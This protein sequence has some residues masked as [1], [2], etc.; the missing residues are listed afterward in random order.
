MKEIVL[1]FLRRGVVACGLGPVVLAVV[2]FILHWVTGLEIL[3]VHEVCV[4]ILSLTGLAFLAGGMN[5]VYRI[6]Q[7]P[8]M[9]AIL[10]HGAVLY[11]GYLVTYIINGWIQQGI[12]PVLVFTG[13]F[14]VGYLVIWCVIY[15]ITRNKTKAVNEV[16]KQKQ[17]YAEY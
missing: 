16:L 3:T 14:V 15:C 13:I 17:Q 12:A 8:L 2:Y 6:E 10:I 9:P 1:G 11:V 7:L 4:G 5:V